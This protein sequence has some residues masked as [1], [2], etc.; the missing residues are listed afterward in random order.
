MQSCCSVYAELLLC[1]YRAAAACRLS[2]KAAELFQHGGDSIDAVLVLI[3]PRLVLL[4]IT[5]R[6]NTTSNTTR[7]PSFYTQTNPI[8]LAHSL[9]TSVRTGTIFHHYPLAEPHA[10]WHWHYPLLEGN[11]FLSKLHETQYLYM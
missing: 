2:A 9:M 5:V 8:K 4:G 3:T 7:W 1:V 11:V 6:C 10:Y